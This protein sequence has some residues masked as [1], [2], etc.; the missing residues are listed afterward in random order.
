M[1]ITYTAINEISSGHSADT[2]YQNTVGCAGY[3]ETILGDTKTT[4]SLDKSNRES[5]SYA[6]QIP[7]KIKTAAISEEDLP[8]WIEWA[9]SVIGG[10]SFTIDASGVA[11]APSSAFSCFIKSNINGPSRISDSDY[12]TFS[13]E[14]IKT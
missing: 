4:Y 10:E 8:K 6:Y 7:V 13:F 14:V 3:D 1:I 9:A 2:V 12:F 5:V 11:N